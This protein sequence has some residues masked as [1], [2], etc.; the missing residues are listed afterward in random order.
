MSNEITVGQ[1]ILEV[2]T[3]TLLGSKKAR[4]DNQRDVLCMDSAL[5]QCEGFLIR[6][7]R[8]VPGQIMWGHNVQDIIVSV[9][10]YGLRVH[11]SGVRKKESTLV[12]LA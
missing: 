1:F 6:C 7:G 11:G 12:I 2:R 4:S 10:A 8:V 9:P 5:A 3:F